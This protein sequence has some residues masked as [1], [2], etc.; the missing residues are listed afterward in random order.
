MK[1]SKRHKKLMMLV[2]ALVAVIVVLV[3]TTILGGKN[4]GNLRSLPSKQTSNVSNTDYTTDEEPIHQVT[5]NQQIALSGFNEKEIYCTLQ[6][7]TPYTNFDDAGIALSDLDSDVSISCNVG[8]DSQTVLFHPNKNNPHNSKWNYYVD[9]KTGR[10]VQH[11]YLLLMDIEITNVKASNDKNSWNDKNIFTLNYLPNIII[12]R[13]DGG[14]DVASDI[15]YFDQTGQCAVEQYPCFELN[16][17][18]TKHFKVG[19]L[20]CDKSSMPLSKIGLSYVW[21]YPFNENNI[22]YW[23][24]LYKS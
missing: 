20:V 13:D 6:S 12:K 10:L 18:E 17:G 7:I 14:F 2:I 4:K 19:Y 23:L 8:L 21:A 11:C 15:A 9:Q 5:V 22:F 3:I 1:L 16:I 24:N